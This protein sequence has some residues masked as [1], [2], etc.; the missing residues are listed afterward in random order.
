[1]QSLLGRALSCLRI[2]GKG[3]RQ[4]ETWNGRQTE[5]G[6]GTQ[7]KRPEEDGKRGREG[8]K[9]AEGRSL[10]DA[11]ENRHRQQED[12]KKQRTGVGV[13]RRGQR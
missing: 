8:E 3:E 4:R 9:K 1:M 12:E 5:P 13:G 7:C 6:V 10:T 2:M 11:E